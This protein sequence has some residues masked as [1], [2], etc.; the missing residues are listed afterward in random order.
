MNI[1]SF[2]AG[3]LIPTRWLKALARLG[4]D[5]DPKPLE[6]MPDS[7][8][9][10]AWLCAGLWLRLQATRAGLLKPRPVTNSVRWLARH[11]VQGGNSHWD[12]ARILNG[13]FQGVAVNLHYG[14]VKPIYERDRDQY[15]AC[16]IPETAELE[17]IG[18]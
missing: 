9:P 14:Q 16:G 15:R 5:V 8:F 7:W 3:V 1:L 4:S 11:H 18:P 10:P 6:A 12:L 2:V 13:Q 17:W